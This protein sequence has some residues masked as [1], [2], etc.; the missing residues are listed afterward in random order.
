MGWILNS[1]TYAGG[2]GGQH[3]VAFAVKNSMANLICSQGSNFD[4]FDDERILRRLNE[5]G[6]GK[7]FNPIN[8]QSDGYSCG[9]FSAISLYLCI[10]LDCDV[11]TIV[12]TIRKDGEGLVQGKSITDFTHVLTGTPK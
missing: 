2:S 3:W 5:L 12:K 7:N 1:A 9:I 6:Y 10:C 4:V 11:S 8:I